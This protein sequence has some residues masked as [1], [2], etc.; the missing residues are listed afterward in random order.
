M[1][2]LILTSN[3]TFINCDN[4]RL[5]KCV[6]ISGSL[7]GTSGMRCDMQGQKVTLWFLFT[8]Q[9]SKLEA[10]VIKYIQRV[11]GHKMSITC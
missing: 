3:Y 11:G 5:R 6:V 8:L 10:N 7:R 2:Y 4:Q 9:N 1:S